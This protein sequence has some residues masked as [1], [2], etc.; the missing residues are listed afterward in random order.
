MK[1]LEINN[2]Y[3]DLKNFIDKC[4]HFTNKNVKV[5]GIVEDK[6]LKSGLAD[7][8][9]GSDGF[10]EVD[11]SYAIPDEIL[12]GPIRLIHD[13]IIIDT[14]NYKGKLIGDDEKFYYGLK[15]YISGQNV[16]DTV[17]KMNEL[18]QSLKSK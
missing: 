11:F 9:P 1:E 6:D 16:L 8:M 4:E 3:E 5:K 15:K 10:F 14:H 7:I 12:S 2:Y 18:I 13:F 17:I